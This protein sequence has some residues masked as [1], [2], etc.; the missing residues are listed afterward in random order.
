MR[1]N[2][3]ELFFRNFVTKIRLDIIYALRE[4]EK[5]V[6]ELCAHLSEEQ[7]KISHNLKHLLDCN[8]VQYEP[9]GKNRIY[10]LNKET[11][12]PLL[13]CVDRHVKSNC[14]TC[15]KK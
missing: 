3:Y 2:S 1:C 5:S 15:S 4:K 14:K 11:I 10:K 6:Q 9:S 13:E 8:I 7:S 12:L